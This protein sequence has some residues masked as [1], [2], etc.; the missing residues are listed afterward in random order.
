VQ[1]MPRHLARRTTSGVFRIRQLS[2]C[3]YRLVS[4]V[5]VLLLSCPVDF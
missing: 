3:L 2:G 5:L 4:S 1:Q